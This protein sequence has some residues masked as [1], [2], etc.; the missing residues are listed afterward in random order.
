MA[1]QISTGAVHHVTPTVADVGRAREFY[2]GVLGFEVAGEF[3]PRVIL[4]NGGALLAIGPASDPVRAISG[5]SF[6]ENRVGLDH[7]CFSLGSRDELEQ[8]IG[9]L[10]EHNVSHGE[11]VDLS[12]LSIYVLMFRDPDNIQIESTAPHS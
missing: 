1:S 11:I 2:T 12:G 3:G 6:N 4:S 10:D 7:V 5:D 9:V 8:A